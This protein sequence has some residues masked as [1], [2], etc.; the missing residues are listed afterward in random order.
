[1][2][3]VSLFFSG[4]FMLCIFSGNQ[5]QAQ[6]WQQVAGG[7][8]FTLAVKTDGTLWAWGRN[9][10]GQLASGNN[11]NYI[12]P[13]QIGSD[14][15]WK[16]VAA[17][18]GFAHAIKNDG[19]LWA[20]GTNSYGAIGDG[21]FNGFYRTP[22]QVGTANNWK[23]VVDGNNFTLVLKT[24]GTLWGWGSNF[25]GLQGNGVRGSETDVAVPTQIGTAN[26]WVKFDLH[27]MCII[28][29]KNNGTIWTWGFN[30]FGILGNGTTN[31]A[32]IPTQVGTDTD[33]ADISMG[34]SH[35]CAVKTNG[36]LWTW[37]ESYNGELGN[38]TT[39]ANQL[40][41]QQAGTDLDWKSV[42]AGPLYTLA[43][44]NN[45]TVWSWGFNNRGQLG[46]S[47]SFSNI[48]VQVGLTGS[49]DQVEASSSQHSMALKT[50]GT[51]W[52]WGMNSYGQLG[53]G[54]AGNSSTPTDIGCPNILVPVKL[55]E[56]KGRNENN[57]N[58][59][60]WKTAQEIN[61]SSFE[62]ELSKDGMN[63][64]KI[65]EQAAA[66][67]SNIILSY[68]FKHRPV[69]ERSF[70]RL[71]M[72]D[73]D[74]SSEYSSVISIASGTNKLMNI[75]P[76]PVSDNFFVERTNG[77]DFDQLVIFDLAGKKVFEKKGNSSSVSV[78]S[79]AKGI[80]T[81]VFYFKGGFVSQNKLIKQ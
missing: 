33:W 49:Y 57:F 72:I 34:S 78:Q 21:T 70:Y 9:N 52:A 35:A 58:T 51:I 71:K 61:S 56:L 67:N 45:G 8:E 64:T 1:M 5:V 43:T 6:C 63:F 76:N 53:T 30:S 26:D 29:L 75:Y 17:G 24:D 28:A 40:S 19:T 60:Y 10:T 38:G 65:G 73:F 79:L 18:G 59:I 2:K 50:D 14:T 16:Q 25:Y 69:Y 13:H 55:I 62:V 22:M 54:V 3:L 12:L 7:A 23:Q 44:K 80:Y 4:L 39:I 41:P 48:P 27:S 31:H 15:D 46:V 66:G 37:G 11:F 36:S 32:F 42:S 74:G 77:H 47:G 81:V 20:W 68:S